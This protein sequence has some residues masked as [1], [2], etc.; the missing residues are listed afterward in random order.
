MSP[1][2]IAITG[3]LCELCHQFIDNLF[4]FGFDRQ[5]VYPTRWLL[6]GS[7]RVVGRRWGDVFRHH[8]TFGDLANSAKMC[9]FCNVLYVDLASLDTGLHQ[10]WLGL[11]PFWSS[12]HSGEN[13][14]KGLF[15]AG[16]RDSLQSMPW[17]SGKIG[18][19]PLHSFRICRREPLTKGEEVHWLDTYRQV[20]VVPTTL[21][22]SLISRVAA[23]W[24]QE[25]TEAHPKC[26]K[27]DSDHALPTRVVDI[28]DSET[29]RV[30]IYESNGEKI[31]YAALS[32][33]WG[34]IIPSVTTTANLKARTNGMDIHELPQNFRDAIEVT[35]I[36]GLRYLWI[37]ALCIIQDSK[38][39]WDQEAGRMYSVY[40]GAYIMI[41]V[42]DSA[43]STKGF[44]KPNR[45]PL[46]LISN[47]YAVQKVYPDINECLTEAP[48]NGRGW[49]MQERLLAKR[50]LHF[51]N[52]QMSWE[53]LTDFKCED[54]NNYTGEWD[55]HFVAKFLTIRKQIGVCAGQ[56]VE[57]DWK[58]WYQLLE[59]YTTR[60]FTISTDKLPAVIGAAALFKSTKPTA[61]YIAGL[62]Q[63]DIAR[64]LL[65]CAHYYHMP[66]RKVWGISTTDDISELSK[67]PTKRAP[68]WS[69][70]ALDGA[71][72]FWALRIGG[73][74]V[75][76]L[77]VAMETEKEAIYGYPVGSIKLRGR[78]AQMFYHPPE[79]S[80]HDVG[81]LTFEPT[82]TPD[83]HYRPTNTCVM[84]LDRQS[85]RLCWAL[86]M[87]ELPTNKYL[88]ILHMRKDGSYKR[89]GMSSAS[90]REIDP[91]FRTQ[92]IYI[93]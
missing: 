25:C 72:D 38:Q 50:V 42:L 13:N 14:L 43:G 34:G 68:S 92:E 75:E 88:L 77:N 84:D 41:S 22:S 11:Y 26:V 86:I 49:C 56:G 64:G 12:G 87:T 85:P 89:V 47:E 33:C 66:G 16:F 45:A 51:G 1:V 39:D 40:A 57:L 5:A 24:R 31:P 21:S 37:D 74:V 61:T 30:C 62:W 18:S 27:S 28:S 69:W 73:F 80:K 4:S 70:A 3:S 60:K 52:E 81:I 35:R 78:L 9:E 44:L 6:G 20:P 58:A 19:I 29:G 36:L 79:D 59:E 71:L 15:R 7:E 82:D 65:W 76:V 83:F 90:W 23:K 2:P 46:A 53:C 91:R 93:T 55:A 8:E 32:H 63:E 67:P 54:G 17:G 48:L 10:G